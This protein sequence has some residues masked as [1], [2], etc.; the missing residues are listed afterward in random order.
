MSPLNCANS[1][2]ACFEA[3]V[4]AFILALTYRE[5]THTA[6]QLFYSQ[7]FRYELLAWH[8]VNPTHFAIQGLIYRPAKMG[9]AFAASCSM[10]QISCRHFLLSPRKLS[11]HTSASRC[12]CFTSRYGIRSRQTRKYCYHASLSTTL[13]VSILTVS[14]P[15]APR[16]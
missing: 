3:S 6:A 11:W 7:N 5:L 2:E 12:A 14:S 10:H 16:L 9:T 1:P 8:A 4:E 15:A 13:Q